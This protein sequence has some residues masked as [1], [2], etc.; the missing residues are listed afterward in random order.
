MFL[1]KFQC[2]PIPFKREITI[3]TLY[4]ACVYVYPFYKFREARLKK[5][6]DFQKRRH[7][8]TP[9]RK[10]VDGSSWLGLR[11]DTF[12]VLPYIDYIEQMPS[13]YWI[14]CCVFNTKSYHSKV[15]AQKRLFLKIGL[16]LNCYLLKRILT[17]FTLDFNTGCKVVTVTWNVKELLFF[18]F[19]GRK[20]NEKTPSLIIRF[21]QKS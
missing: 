19:D 16:M 12:L 9:R 2:L 20:K 1:L 14:R 21:C 10:G 4:L 13:C 5:P 17:L 11:I 8:R 15:T 18:T 7:P 3:P 6:S